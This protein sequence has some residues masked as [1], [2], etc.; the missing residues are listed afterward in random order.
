MKHL[1]IL[2]VA[3]LLG[4]V[5]SAQS[6]EDIIIYRFSRTRSWQQHEASPDR[7]GVLKGRNLLVG[8][9]KDSCYW[10]FDRGN[11]KV[12]EVCYFTRSVDGVL[13]KLY[14]V[15]EG[16]FALLETDPT[17]YSDDASGDGDQI[18][19]MMFLP[20]TKVGVK[21]QTC[22]DSDELNDSSFYDPEWEPGD[23]YRTW[24]YGYVWDLTGPTKILTGLGEVAS[25]LSG[26]YQGN[27]RDHTESSAG[28]LISFLSRVDVG[29]QS[30]SLDMRL[31]TRARTVSVNSQTVNSMQNGIETVIEVVEKLGYD[32]SE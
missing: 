4:Q 30:A 31:T 12:T 24:N 27:E 5:A 28:T 25:L 8:T 10:I 1:T 6:P 26:F 11:N 19:D 3:G 17:D 14:E 29:P 23:P 32:Y 16:S 13:Q 22:R 21:M 18:M 20:T 2:L 9:A 15:R 7:N